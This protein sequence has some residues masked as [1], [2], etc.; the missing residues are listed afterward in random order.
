MRRFSLLL[1]FLL[2]IPASADPYVRLGAGIDSSAEVTLR[3]RDCGSTQPPAL[4]GCGTGIDGRPLAA[5]GDFG[6]SAVVE[7]AAGM[8]LGSHARLEIALAERP[9]LALDAR[10]NFLGV[11]GD[12]PVRAGLDS[13]SAMLVGIYD[14]AP[15]SWRIRPF[16]QAGAGI[17]RN[18]L[19]SVTYTFPAIARSAV[20]R[21]RGGGETG[22]AWSGGVGAALR[23]SPDFDVELTVSRHDFGSVRTDAGSALIVRPGR[24]LSIDIDG[25]T[26]EVETTG[27]MLSVRCRL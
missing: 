22:F 23:L 3:D 18:Q 21:T 2:A 20:T 10:A 13:R 24:Q 17:A 27:V 26:A 5:R 8:E 25:T 15:G 19:E 1:S 12:Q 9:N 14:P 11:S 7:L 16:V 6:E 4:F